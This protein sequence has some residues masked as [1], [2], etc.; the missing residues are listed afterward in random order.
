MS[1]GVRRARRAVDVTVVLVGRDLRASY[2]HALLGTLW[3]PIQALV[4]VGVLTF[5]FGR[6]VPL[7]LDDYPVF[8]FTG[9][10]MWQTV[11]GAL[12]RGCNAFTENRDL[13][14]RPGFPSGVLPI[15]SVG[16]AVATYALSLPVLFV[17]LAASG[18]LRPSALLLPVVA[19]AAAAVVSGPALAL[20]TWNVRFRDVRHLVGAV[21]GVAFYLTP[22]FYDVDRIPA[23]LRWIADVN[24]FAVIVRLHRQILYEGVLPDLGLLGLA[25][26][27]A[28]IGLAIGAAA[29]RRAEPQLADDL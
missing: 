8:V 12:T 25:G 17:F 21:L 13:V 4:Q 3:A 24:P 11:S 1:R 27:A 28:A 9:I 5:L 26:A 15:V 29:F 18:R 20:A 14:R 22:V 19:I 23:E 6:V 16:G 10:L 2:G 7:D